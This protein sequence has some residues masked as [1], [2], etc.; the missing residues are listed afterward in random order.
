L[1]LPARG[2]AEAGR[3]R[4][5]VGRVAG[6]GD[7]CHNRRYPNTCEKNIGQETRPQQRADVI[8]TFNLKDF[9]TT[10]LAPLDVE[11]RHPYEFISSGNVSVLPNGIPICSRCQ[12]FKESSHYLER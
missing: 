2:R 3:G 4:P 1:S 6:S 9:P 10:D 7:H 5:S 11:A 8:V 12:V